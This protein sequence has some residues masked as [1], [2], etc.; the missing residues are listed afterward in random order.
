MIRCFDG[1]FALDTKNTTYA[2]R[3][4]PTGQLEHL[5]YGR[6][7]QL[8]EA[9]IASL[10]DRHAFAPGN[11]VT[12]DAEHPEFSLEDMRLEAS[13]YGKGDIR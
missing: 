9:A 5:C 6:S 4:L 2:F 10:A 11:T 3:V 7:M 12:Y 8:G 1:A 13:F